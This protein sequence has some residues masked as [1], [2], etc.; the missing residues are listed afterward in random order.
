MVLSGGQSFIP[1]ITHTGTHT[2]PHLPT[3]NVAKTSTIFI[4]THT[5]NKS[6]IWHITHTGIAK[7]STIFITTHTTNHKYHTLH[8]LVTGTHTHP[9][10]PTLNV[11]KTSTIFITTHTINKSHIIHTGTHPH[12][13]TLNVAKTSTIF[14]TTHNQI[15]NHPVI[16]PSQAGTGTQCETK[17]NSYIAKFSTSKPHFHRKMKFHS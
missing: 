4:T 3:L 15:T 9:H 11:A 16:H 12:L 13:P 1:F 5:I 10:L 7:T 14:I 6:Q 17:W 2:H 8:I